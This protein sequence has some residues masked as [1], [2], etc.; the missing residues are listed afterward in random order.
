MLLSVRLRSSDYGTLA[1][2]GARYHTD[3]K[4]AD[5]DGEAHGREGTGLSADHVAKF[6]AGDD[7]TLG[8]SS[9]WLKVDKGTSKFQ[10]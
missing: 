1:S 2:L 7:R 9:G 8:G 3:F 10:L 6:N 5:F 4:A